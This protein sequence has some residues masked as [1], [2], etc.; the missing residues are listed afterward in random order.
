MNYRRIHDLLIARATDRAPMGYCERHHIIPKCLGGPNAELNLVDL[1]AREHYVVHQL[2]VKLH[3]DNRNLAHA[4]V[5]MAKQCTVARAYEWLR[6]RHAA[7]ASAFHKGKSHPSLSVESRKKIA[8]SLS[9]RRQ[10]E[11]TKAKRAKTLIGNK[12]CKG[13]KHTV[14]A[15]NN[16]SQ[17]HIGHHFSSEIR[18][19]IST[20]LIGKVRSEESR[21]RI[22]MAQKLRFSQLT[23][24]LKISNKLKG[25]PWSKARRDS[26]NRRFGL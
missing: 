9:G 18:A 5:R 3:P 11:E 14:K 23:E 26:Y 21:N 16:M 19:Q 24:R 6:K 8:F 15:K 4:A 1:T 2:L 25:V 13:Y 7:A 17:S 10:S 12:R 20:A 22:S